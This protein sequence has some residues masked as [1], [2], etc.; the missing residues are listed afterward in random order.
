[1]ATM[2]LTA[3]TIQPYLDNIREWG[4][5]VPEWWD[6][7]TAKEIAE[8]FNG[9]GSDLTPKYIRWGLTHVYDF[10]IEAVIIHDVIFSMKEKYGLTEEDFY[11]ANKNLK[12]NAR[13]CLKYKQIYSWTYRQW[14]YAKAWIAEKMCNRYGLE[15]WAN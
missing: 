13:I 1:M 5:V 10:G 3:K 2:K 4:L 7:L 14:C 9:V 8:C 6:E 12:I 11:E 15:A